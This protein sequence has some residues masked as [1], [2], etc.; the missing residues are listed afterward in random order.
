MRGLLAVCFAVALC[1]NASAEDYPAM[2]G[3]G[4][5]SCAEFA[6]FYRARPKETETEFF[7]WAMGFMSGF[8]AKNL[9]DQGTFFDLKAKSATDMQSF[10]REYCNAHP[11]TDYGHGV[12]ELIN[13]LPVIKHK[14]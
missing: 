8:N 14:Q 1:G 7:A 11:L 9:M 2:W 5:F 10:L 3:H 6:K 4:L 13:S 12:F